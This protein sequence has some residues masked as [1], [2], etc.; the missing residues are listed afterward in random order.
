MES[1]EIE[2]SPCLIGIAAETVE[3]SANLATVWL[4]HLENL[5]VSLPAMDDN[6]KVE[7]DGLAYLDIENAFLKIKV[8]LQIMEVDA[9]FANGNDGS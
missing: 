7:L 9:D 4:Q 5:V 8:V 6:W 1:S 3:N 2:N